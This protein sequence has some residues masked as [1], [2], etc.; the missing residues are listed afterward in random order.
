MKANPSFC[1]KKHAADGCW[2]V[3]TC[4]VQHGGGATL[5]HRDD[6]ISELL[7]PFEN[8]IN[9]F[10]ITRLSQVAKNIESLCIFEVP[11]GY[12]HDPLGTSPR[13]KNPSITYGGTT[14]PVTLTELGSGGFGK[15]LG[16]A[17]H[18]AG[19][20]SPV[21]FAV[22][23]PRSPNRVIHEQL[24]LDQQ[25][26]RPLPCA[27][28]IVPMTKHSKNVV[29]MPVA[30]GTLERWE[31]KCTPEQA[32]KVVEIVRQGA[33]CLFEQGFVYL[34][35]KPENILYVC[36]AE[37]ADL[38]LGDLGSLV[39]YTY[40]YEDPRPEFMYHPDDVKTPEQYERVILYSLTV[41]Y[42]LLR[43]PEFPFP[44]DK[45]YIPWKAI[46]AFWIKHGPSPLGERDRFYMTRLSEMYP[47]V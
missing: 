35:I 44:A 11:G 6:S 21:E 15:V 47:T 33:R 3:D 25:G 9:W 7:C 29:I 46:R 13:T 27:S 45:P 12:D 20:E 23:A 4:P 24:L 2:Q 19:S 26:D 17:F 1:T 39:G 31:G 41:L 18:P 22:K 36:S 28:Y 40:T 37:K 16:V 42:F 38:L 14:Y 43:F 5:M 8:N 30:S 10:D 32:H 34:D